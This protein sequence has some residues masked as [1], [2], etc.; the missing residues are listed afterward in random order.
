MDVHII[1]G[2]P[3]KNLVKPLLQSTGFIIG[4]DG[5]AALATAENIRLDV[6]L[7]DFDSIDETEFKMIKKN[8]EQI[9]TF[10][11]EKDDTDAEL[12]LVYVLENIQ[13]ENIYIYNWNGGRLDHLHSILML[14]LQKRFEPLISKLHFVDIDN[15]ISYYVPGDYRLFKN[16]S[17]Q[18][19]SLILL[20]EV[21]GLTFQE[22]KY[23]VKDLDY[24]DPRA[25]ISNEF[26]DTEAFLSF[27]KGIIA[28]IQSRDA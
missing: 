28:V 17:M 25:L 3:Q 16:K 10:P 20:T 26:L 21:A 18:Y 8:A 23:P 5:G 9:Y 24:H 6:A 13:A 27:T 4:V 19:V 15:L 12:A 14:A 7:G 1:L 22:V 11:S 2:A